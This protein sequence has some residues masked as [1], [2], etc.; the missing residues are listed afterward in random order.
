[1]EHSEYEYFEM[2]QCIKVERSENWYI[3]LEG[4][5]FSVAIDSAVLW[6]LY[7]CKRAYE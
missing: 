2:E 7:F 5:S 3:L 1:M 6:I 4:P